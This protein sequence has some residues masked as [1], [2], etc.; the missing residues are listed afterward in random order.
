MLV[1]LLNLWLRMTIENS[2]TGFHV[3]LSLIRAKASRAKKKLAKLAAQK[4]EKRVA[5]LAAG[6]EWASDEDSDETPPVK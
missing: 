3:V 5:A 6:L 2:M 1:H 4:E